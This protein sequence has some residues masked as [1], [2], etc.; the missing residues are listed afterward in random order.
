MTATKQDPQVN[1]GSDN[2]PEI[3]VTGLVRRLWPYFANYPFLL[4][5]IFIALLL[6]A[7]F[8]VALPICTKHIIDFALIGDDMVVEVEKAADKASITSIL[9]LLCIGVVV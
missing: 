5:V 7:L 2:Q 1:A 3:T 8:N 6:E 9:I 4:S